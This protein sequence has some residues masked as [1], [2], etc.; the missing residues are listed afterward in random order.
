MTN[1]FNLLISRNTRYYLYG[2]RMFDALDNSTYDIREA[3]P[4]KLLEMVKDNI[5]LKYNLGEMLFEDVSRF[6][7]QTAYRL[8]EC[9][10]ENQKLTLMME[11]EVKFGSNLLT[12]SLAFNQ[13]KLLKETWE[14]LQEKLI[15]E[16]PEW[17]DNTVSWVSDKASDLGDW[18][19]DKASSAK[20]W[21]SDTWDTAKQKAGQ[22]WDWAKEKAGQF[23]TWLIS[24]GVPTVMEGL[25]AVMFS[26]GGAIA[27]T[28]ISFIPYLNSLNYIAWGA[29]LAWDV[30][31]AI[32]GR[33]N[34]MYIVIDLV[35]VIFSGGMAKGL[36]TAI[37]K[38][39]G[40]AAK[41]TGKSLSYV[42]N[43]LNKTAIGRTV[44]SSV[45]TIASGFGKVLEIAAK[46][47]SWVAE[48]FGS[49]ALKNVPSKIK[50]F[51]DKIVAALKGQ[52]APVA[53][54]VTPAVIPAATKPGLVSKIANQ[55][56]GKST[57]GNVALTSG[58]VGGITYGLAS[59]KKIFGTNAAI[60]QQEVMA[61]LD[62]LGPSEI[63]VE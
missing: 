43:L 39:F 58:A 62:K 52:P 20:K 16:W 33:A 1:D 56:F 7:R 60:Q 23:S 35:G 51:F 40:S 49:N 9:F 24:K 45:G 46:G 8:F 30:L 31:E 36:M 5:I 34:W 26:W 32:N 61:S 54:T 41:L 15:N 48:K 21:V 11:Y 29:L 25:R 19:S 50:G 42:V 3:S 13:K 4:S 28:I 14:Y 37:G 18:V 53:S 27:S 22:A 10:E 47:V 63:E 55:K 44:T 17:V 6:T 2:N 59:D 38:V 12:E 57:V